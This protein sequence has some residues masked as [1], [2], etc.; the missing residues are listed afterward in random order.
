MKASINGIDIHYTIEGEG[1]WVVMSHSL[2]CDS[3]MW[4]PQIKALSKKYKVLAID[5]RGH[6]GSSA[7]AG[8]YTLDM[9]ADDVKG[10]FDQLGVKDANWIGLSMGG[11][12]GQATALKYPGIF[13]SMVLADTTSGYSPEGVKMWSERVTNVRAKGV[14]IVVQGTL[15]RWFTEPYRNAHPDVIATVGA[16]ALA[17]TATT[18]RLGEIKTPTLVICGEQDGGTPPSMAKIIHEGIKGSEYVLLPE[19]AHLSNMEQP[20]KFTAAV[21]AFYKRIGV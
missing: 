19:A 21:E 18:A 5:T 14:G 16:S 13:K 9:L 20:E 11:I 7:P 10:L 15:E 6:G 3:R 17:T 8:D 2:A 4:E 12:I 1:P